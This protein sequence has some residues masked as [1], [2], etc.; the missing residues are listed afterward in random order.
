MAEGT[1]GWPPAGPDLSG[2]FCETVVHI[3]DVVGTN[4]WRRLR[5]T[6]SWPLATMQLTQ[7]FTGVEG[8]TGRLRSTSGVTGTESSLLFLRANRG[9]D[10]QRG[11]DAKRFPYPHHQPQEGEWEGDSPV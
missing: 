3:M 2:R 8:L 4:H 7:D 1:E 11:L 9:P 6:S 10:V 5:G